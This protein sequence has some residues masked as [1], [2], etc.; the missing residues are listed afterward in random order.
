MSNKADVSVKRTAH[1]KNKFLLVVSIIMFITNSMTIITNAIESY[2]QY[3]DA[4]IENLSDT[5]D[6]NTALMGIIFVF[7]I[8]ICVVSIYAA[9][10]GIWQNKLIKCK[11]LGIVI[12]LMNTVNFLTSLYFIIIISYPESVEV[13]IAAIAIAIVGIYL[14]PVLYYLGAVSAIKK[15]SPPSKYEKVIR[16][17]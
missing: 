6:A 16:S 5:L 2:L 15:Q 4:K 9:I 3:K 1:K 8:A 13:I 11:K 14:L 12:L 7:G 17:I 10:R